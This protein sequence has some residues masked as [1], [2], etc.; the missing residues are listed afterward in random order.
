[1][2]QVLAHE[3]VEMLVMVKEYGLELVLGLLKAMGLEQGLEFL[4][5]LGKVHVLGLVLGEEL[6]GELEEYGPMGQV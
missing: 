6:G 2:V 5:A 3:L 1:M 4:M